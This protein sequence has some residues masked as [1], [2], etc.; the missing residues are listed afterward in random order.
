[1]K[2]IKA[3]RIL[4]VLAIVSGLFGGIVTADDKENTRPRRVRADGE[5]AMSDPESAEVDSQDERRTGVSVT[6][7]RRH[8]VVRRGATG[9]A[10]GTAK[11]ATAAAKG[12]AKG[13]TIGA[14]GV[15]RGATIAAEST[16]EGAEV[17]GKSTAKG[18]KTAARG[19]KKV[20]KKV[21][22]AFK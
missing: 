5:S 6:R 11:G 19:T 18:A 14:K 9:A 16:A 1:M 17:A 4:I 13:A 3:V 22:D 7:K 2:I 12:T 20:G 8:G 21:I 10:K 15:A